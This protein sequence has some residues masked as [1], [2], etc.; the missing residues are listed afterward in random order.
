MKYT[1]NQIINGIK[2]GDTPILKWLYENYGKKAF[3]HVKKNKGNKTDADDVFQISMLRVREKLS[4]NAYQPQA[5]ARFQT[6]FM[7]FVRNVWREIQR[8]KRKL[9][10]QGIDEIAYSLGEDSFE[11]ISKQLVLDKQF[12]DLN[13]AVKALNEDCRQLIRMHYEKEQKLIDIAYAIGEKDVTIRQR[14]RRCL[15]RL[16]KS[17]T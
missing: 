13:N 8:D 16:R 5:N 4:T 3:F 14:L 2:N 1:D 15:G 6:Y 9:P 7:G 17:L 12:T 11:V 10:I